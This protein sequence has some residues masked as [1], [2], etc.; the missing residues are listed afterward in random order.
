MPASTVGAMRHSPND[1]KTPADPSAAHVVI[2]LYPFSENTQATVAL[3]RGYHPGATR[4]R[5]WSGYLPVTRGDLHGLSPALVARLLA[6]ALARALP[7]PD[8][9]PLAPPADTARAAGSPPLEGP[10]GG[11]PGQLPLPLELG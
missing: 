4:L 10:Q 7:A 8:G 11:L 6:D 1:K 3:V 9:E 2:S 5:V